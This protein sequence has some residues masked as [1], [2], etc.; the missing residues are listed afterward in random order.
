MEKACPNETES[1]CPVCLK[2]IKATRS[3]E[4][5]QVF[6]VKECTDHGV[7]RTVI[8]RGEPSM[9]DW[10]RSKNPVHPELCYGTVAKG[11]PFD[12]GL[13]A[14]HEQL[15]CSV[16]VEVTDRCNLYCAVCFADS[17]RGEEA[18]PSP[19]TI[20]RLLE[21]A[22]A[23]AGPC[24]LQLSG[25]EPTLRDDLPDIV[26]IARRVGYSFIQVNTNGLRLAA[27]LDY[28]KRAPG[29][30]SLI[31]LSSVRRTRRRCLPFLA[32]KSAPGSEAPGR[33]ELRRGRPRGR[34]GPYPCKGGEHAALSGTSY[35]WP[36]GSPPPCGASISSLSAISAASPSRWATKAASPCRS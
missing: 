9:A 10:R 27:D 19:A 20:S 6:L 13:C 24:N 32:G 12:C 14:V 23:A 31:G 29:R 5:D 22:F 26:D 11:C 34:H 16:L 25:G 4:G 35:G 18:D 30:G 17:G 3:F 21:R 33:Q 7:F 1:L 15:P 2:R 28:A 8:W 36:C